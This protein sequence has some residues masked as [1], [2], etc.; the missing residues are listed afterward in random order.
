[1]WFQKWLFAWFVTTLKS[2]D[3]KLVWACRFYLGQR[4][5]VVIA[6]LDLLKEVMVKQFDHFHD[7]PP[8][9][10]LL[11]KKSGTP[12]GLFNARGEYWKK[13]RVTLSPTFSVAKMKMV[14]QPYEL[15]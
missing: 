10:D 2:F 11:R 9:P 13:L 14:I 7:R 4:P 6:D 8:A 1:M 15:T 5:I 12:R 3:Y